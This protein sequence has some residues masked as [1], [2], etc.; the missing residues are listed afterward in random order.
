MIAVASIAAPEIVPVRLPAL[1]LQ[2]YKIPER[3]EQLG[4]LEDAVVCRI[5]AKDAKED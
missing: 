2:Y 3:E 5:A 1:C 4:S